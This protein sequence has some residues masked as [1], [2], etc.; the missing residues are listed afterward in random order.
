MSLFGSLSTGVS[1]LNAQSEAIS[2]I[3]DN[4][5]NVNTTGYK[6]SS[7][8]F[9]QL[10]TTAGVSGVAFNS[11]GVNTDVI[12]NQNVQ[13]SLTATDNATDLALSGN[14]FFVLSSERNITSDTAFFY[15]RDGAFREDSRGFLRHP[16]GNYLMGWRTE[17]DGTIIDRQNPEPVELQ[18]VGASARATQSLELGLNLTSTETPHIY[19]DPT[20]LANSLDAVVADPNLADF[21]IDD[22]FFDAQGGA[23]DISVA[24]VKRSQNLWDFAV[25][26]DG[27]NVPGGTSGVNTRI[28]NGTVRF[29]ENGSLNYVGGQSFNVDWTGGV[30]QGQITLDFGDYTGTQTTAGP[31]V[32]FVDPAAA[33]TAGTNLQA[34]FGNGVQDVYVDYLDTT[35]QGIAPAPGSTWSIDYNSATQQVTLYDAQ[36]GSAG[37]GAAIAGPI[38]ITPGITNVVNFG[39]GMTVTLDQ[40]QLAASGGT[41]FNFNLGIQDEFGTGVGTD[42]VIQFAS[43]YNT[44]FSTQDGFGSGTLAGV[45]VDDEGFVTGS[46]TN[47]E[48]KKLYKLQIGVFQDPNSLSAITGNIF[49][50]TDASGRV[51]F[52]EAGIGNTATVKSGSLESST[53]DIASE[54]SNL[55][56]SQR[57]YQSSSKI[58][59]TVDQMLNELLN[60]R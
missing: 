5:A 51:L 49:Q 10:V 21:V 36:D 29:N 57:A 35:W 30:P 46:F 43:A 44:L 18:T 55:I 59:S 3:S 33:P 41:A 37:A 60:L 24:F 38:T 56:I 31:I 6:A 8:L 22:R 26:T 17:S 52:K 19:S 16:S 42:G 58:V 12:T 32:G 45:S 47:G 1:G 34:T 9:N 4:L 20:S 53:V 2:V 25:Y 23:R 11:G 54:F 13:G 28:H 27:A 39:N 14:G 7:A 50:E 15:S 48:T 40:T